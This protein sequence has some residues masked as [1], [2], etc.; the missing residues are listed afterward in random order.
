MLFRSAAATSILSLVAIPIV[1]WLLI[2]FASNLG[3]RLLRRIKSDE[4]NKAAREQR[5]RTL[6]SVFHAAFAT[7]VAGV[8]SLLAAVLSVVSVGVLVAPSVALS[9]ATEF[10]FSGVPTGPR[11][12]CE[13][14]RS[15]TDE[16][17]R[18][19]TGYLMSRLGS[20]EPAWRD[21]RHEIGRAHV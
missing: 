21:C 19:T 17:A 4:D 15:D 7:V 5:A 20:E 1:A 6:L 13:H 2:W 9:E 16:M 14:A 11:S 18:A 3:G 12:L 8:P 10:S